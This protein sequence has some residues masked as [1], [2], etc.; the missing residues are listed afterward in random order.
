MFSETCRTTASRAY[1][2]RTRPDP[3]MIP[4]ASVP[5]ASRTAD[6]SSRSGGSPEG[7][8]AGAFLRKRS[9]A[10]STGVGSGLALCHDAQERRW[11]SRWHATS[12]HTRCR[13]PDRLCGWNHL[14]QIRQGRLRTSTHRA[15]GSAY[16]STSLVSARPWI[17]FDERTRVN[18][19]ERRSCELVDAQ[20]QSV[21]PLPD[22]EISI[23]L[24]VRASASSGVGNPTRQPS[25]CGT[26]WPRSR[27]C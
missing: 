4:A 1:S 26:R 6:Q 13:S 9:D 11:R 17:T 20:D 25:D 18:S 22:L 2:W 14:R 12:L 16:A 15:S 5:T 8:G 27:A 7:G 10:R 3:R 19:H 23:P 21:A 24:H